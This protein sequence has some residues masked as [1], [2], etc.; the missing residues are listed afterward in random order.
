MRCRGLKG[1]LAL[2][3]ASSLRIVRGGGKVEGFKLVVDG[4]P[5]LVKGICYSPVP[6]GENTAFPPYGD[7]FTP[8]FAYIWRRDLRL[9]KAMG[10]NTL[11]IYGWNNT[12]DHSLFLDEVK[13]YGLK[14]LITFYLGSATQ[15]PVST[16]EQRQGLVD[17]FGNQVKMYAN[18]SAVLMWYC[19]SADF[20]L[21]AY[22]A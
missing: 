7:Y 19:N 6:I 1:L 20:S 15:H 16:P 4:E 2:L 18:H 8:E 14:A 9:I 10:A 3:F 13:A 11:R 21:R 5:F 17:D 22:R 12:V